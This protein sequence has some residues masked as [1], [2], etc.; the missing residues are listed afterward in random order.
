MELLKFP[1]PNL[2]AVCKEVT[3]FDEK[4][5]IILNDM[6]DI[7]LKKGG[8]GLAANQVG[9][10]IRAFVMAGSDSE[11]IFFVNPKVIKKS[12]VSANMDE[13]CLSSPGEFLRLRDRPAWVQVEYQDHKGNHQSKVFMEIRSVAVMHE[14]DHLNGICFMENKTI[15]RPIRKQ[16]AKKWGLK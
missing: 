11:K 2:F 1:H 8:I 14:L 10:D 3:V 9:L 15:P 5:G 12:E 7:M 4:L 16:L 13:G 6:W